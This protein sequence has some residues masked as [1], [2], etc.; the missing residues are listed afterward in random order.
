MVIDLTVRVRRNV[1][2]AAHELGGGE[3]GVLLHLTSGQYHRVDTVGWTIWSLLDGARSLREVAEEVRA[4]YPD[5]P[6]HVAADVQGF[7]ADLVRRDLA[8]VV[9]ADQAGQGA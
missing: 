4:R 6:D 7:V 2:V 8:E 1:Q 5:A 9:P 3:G